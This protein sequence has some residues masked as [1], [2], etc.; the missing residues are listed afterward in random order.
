MSRQRSGYKTTK[1]KPNFMLIQWFESPP[2]RSLII[3]QWADEV[4]DFVNSAT[5]LVYFISDLR[6]GHVTDILVLRELA[7][8]A[9]HKNWGAGVS[10]SQ[11]FGS[12]VYVGLFARLNEREKPVAESLEA[13]LTS[14]E[15][16]AP[17]L[18]LDINWEA[19]LEVHQH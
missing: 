13:A 16:V 15:E 1:L 6:Q 4:T 11:S 8:L 14:L 7:A 18:T 19:V 3:R 17:G 2:D 5:G 10:F 12:G 9:K